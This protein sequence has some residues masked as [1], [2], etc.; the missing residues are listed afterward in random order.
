MNLLKSAIQYEL[1]AFYAQ[2]QGHAVPRRE[3]TQSAFTQARRKLKYEA[4]VELN[5]LAVA[6]FYAEAPIR[7][8]HD[9]RLLAVDGSGLRLPDVPEVRETFSHTPGEVPQGRLVELY[10]VL[11][12]IVLGAEFSDEEIGEGFHADCLLTGAQAGDLVLYDRGFAAFHLMAR[13][14][15]Q[16]IDFCMRTPVARFKKVVEFVRSGKRED[17]V[18][19]PPSAKAKRDCRRNGLCTKPL[20]V[21]LIRVD[22]P[23]GEVEVLITSLDEHIPAAEF[24]ELYFK[25]WGIEEAYKLQKCRGELENFSGRTVQS[26]YQDIYAK[27]LTMNL[28]AMCAFAAEEQAQ[29]RTAHRQLGYRINR[30]KTLAKVKY[31]LVCAVLNIQDRM[32]SLLRWIAQDVE[33]IRPGRKY[34]RRSPGIKKPGFHQSYKRLA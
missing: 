29:E 10:D 14:R 3:I 5:D 34:E 2:L 19:I 32:E 20:R 25:R 33:A 13:H 30:A 22:L 26:L 16:G 11:N 23:D 17:W 31:H 4:F 12:Q 8:W 15:Q 24:A 21:R 27:L 7:R 1:D 28:A 6:A 9:Y 18:E